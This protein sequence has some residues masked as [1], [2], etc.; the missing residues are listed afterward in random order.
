MFFYFVFVFV[1]SA[2]C[3]VVLKYNAERDDNDPGQQ[4]EQPQHTKGDACEQSGR[5]E[6]FVGVAH[7]AEDEP[8]LCAHK[9]VEQPREC[10]VIGW[11]VLA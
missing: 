6:I 1:F 10:G 5:H 2:L 11:H 9:Q 7:C 8:Q 4:I 3:G